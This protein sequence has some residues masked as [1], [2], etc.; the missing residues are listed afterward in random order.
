MAYEIVNSLRSKSTIRVTGNTDTLI[1]LSQLSPNTSLET[2]TAAA[3]THIKTSSN[4]VWT[5]YR[6]DSNTSTKL[7]ELNLNDT[8]NLEDL[9][10]GAL[11]NSSTSNIFVTNTGTVGTLLLVVAKTATY[12]TDTGIL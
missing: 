5:I 4:G 6:G 3:I 2:V 9:G 10:I 11:S 12:S 8:I 7:L 1:T